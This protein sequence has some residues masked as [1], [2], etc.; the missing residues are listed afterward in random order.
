[1]RI[2]HCGRPLEDERYHEI[3][4]VQGS[5][6][7]IVGWYRGYPVRGEGL[8]GHGRRLFACKVRLIAES[9]VTGK[10]LVPKS[11][12]RYTQI[13]IR[14]GARNARYVHPELLEEVT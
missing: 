5:L 1:M 13:D 9:P 4:E 10:R 6:P 7:P 2:C 11:A 3:H 8:L 12:H 14:H